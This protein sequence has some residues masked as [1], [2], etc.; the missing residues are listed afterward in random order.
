MKKGNI[1]KT[2]LMGLFMATVILTATILVF[3]PNIGACPVT[4]AGKEKQNEKQNQNQYV[5]GALNE[6][7][8]TGVIVIISP[9]QDG[10]LYQ[11]ATDWTARRAACNMKKK[12]SD[13]LSCCTQLGSDYWFEC[14]AG[15]PNG[16]AQCWA[17]AHAKTDAC[18]AGC[19]GTAGGGGSGGDA[20]PT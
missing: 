15:N 13:C 9:D 12:Q 17:T 14:I 3:E 4:K 11:H 10:P 2:R 16:G 18:K 20:Q 7:A 19:S 5:I 1:G 8:G 6:I